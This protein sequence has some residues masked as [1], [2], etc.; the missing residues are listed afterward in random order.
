MKW[1]SYRDIAVFL[2]GVLVQ[3]AVMVG[4]FVIKG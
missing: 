3:T 1:I 4:V 2:L